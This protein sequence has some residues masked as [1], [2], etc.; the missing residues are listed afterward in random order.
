MRVAYGCTDEIRHVT[1]VES[2]LNSVISTT[3]F[4][5]VYHPTISRKGGRVA[6]PTFHEEPGKSRAHLSNVCHRVGL[7]LIKVQTH[8][9]LL[10]YKLFLNYKCSLRLSKLDSI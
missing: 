2:S 3:L 8:Y 4:K 10:C 5:R 9:I 7:F 1:A 6:V